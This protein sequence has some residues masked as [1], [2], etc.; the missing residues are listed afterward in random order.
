[1]NFRRQSKPLILGRAILGSPRKT[2]CQPKAYTEDIDDL[3]IN[4][5]SYLLRKLLKENDF[6]CR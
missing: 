3:G 1:M 4:T 5:E 6:G 2:L